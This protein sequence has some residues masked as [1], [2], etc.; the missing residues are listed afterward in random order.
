MQCIRYT[1]TMAEVLADLSKLTVT[2]DEERD[3]ALRETRH[4]GF[5]KENY[6]LHGCMV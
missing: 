2:N 6:A 5:N 4:K 3:V 1:R